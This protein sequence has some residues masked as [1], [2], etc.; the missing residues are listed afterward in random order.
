MRNVFL[1]SGQKKALEL[2]AKSTLREH[3]YWTG[4]TLLAYHYLHHRKS[5]DVDLFSQEPFS[6]QEVDA[7]AQTLKN[8]G[9][10]KKITYARIFDR[11]EFFFENGEELRVEFVY[12]NGE[13]KTLRK[14]GR[15][16]GV[17]IDSLEDVVAN[18]VL[19]YFDRNE[20]K[21]LFDIYFI[22]TNCGFTAQKLIGLARQKTGIE[23]PESLF[24]SESYKSMALIKKLTPLLLEETEEDKRKLLTKIE[25]YFK[26]GSSQFLRK[27]VGE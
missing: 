12:Y 18:K 14:K 16:L 20:P 7:F 1:T 17:S 26:E 10:F 3:F 21:D 6:F 27:Q 2:L 15:L 13:K 23:F 8:E 9:G 19:A 24:W 11:H 22:M 4:G 5:I 25:A